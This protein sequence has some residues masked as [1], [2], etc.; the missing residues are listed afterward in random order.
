MRLLTLT[1]PGGV[2]KTRLALAV[3]ER[4]G[5]EFV[6]GVWFVPLAALHDPAYVIPAVVAALGIAE[7]PD[8]SPVQRL[9]A[10]LGNQRVL[11]VLDNVEHVIDAAA[12]VGEVLANCPRL[13]LLATSRIPL[14]L[15]GEREYP[16]PP[17][18]L[19]AG[20]DAGDS[21][22]VRLFVER[23]R[24]VQ[25]S[26]TLSDESVPV[27]AA[28]CR[29]LDGLPLAIELAAARLRM[30]PPKDLLARLDQPLALLTGGP[31]DAPD[32][33]RTLRATIRWSYD[34][35]DEDEQRLFRTMSACRG[36]WTLDATEA[37][38]DDEPD[39]FDHLSTLVEHGL[40][41]QLQS[42]GRA[43][44]GMLEIVRE[45]G[46]EQLTAL[47]E[48]DDARDRHARY[49]LDLVKQRNPIRSE[50]TFAQ[51]MGEIGAELDNIRAAYDWVLAPDEPDGSL[52]DAVAATHEWLD[53]FWRGCGFF[54]EGRR[55]MERTLA[56]PNLSDPGRVFSLNGAGYM[57]TEQGDFEPAISY[58]EEAMAI[59]LDR[60]DLDAQLDALFGL[61]RI[62]LWRADHE[63]TV[64][65][66]EQGLAIA[67]EIG[68]L[69]EIA[70]F[71]SNIAL[72]VA[73]LGDTPRAK[74]LLEEAL[75]IRRN[76]RQYLTPILHQEL[77][78]IAVM[79][80]DTGE[81]RRLLAEALS[82]ERQHGPS[83][84]IADCLEASASL[85]VIEERPARAARLYGA[86]EML[87]YTIGA[88][89]K[90]IDLEVH[91][92]S[93]V[94][95]GKALVSEQAWDEAWAEGR[96]M[97]LDDAID[98]ALAFDDE[99]ESQ[100][101]KASALLSARE[102]EVLRLL[103]D[104]RSN[105]EIAAELFISPHTAANHVASIMNKLGVGSRTAAATWAV[106]NGLV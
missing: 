63:R 51:I 45:F 67:R 32:R 40:V 10:R 3:V 98:Y 81:A 48:S 14:H 29:K 64:E 25:P 31:R 36:G 94:E 35:L 34:L 57:A 65:I 39:A 85:A 7:H 54:A 86:A 77:A 97:P 52:L 17:L 76:V 66:H 50:L 84:I 82:T 6:D 60:G 55:W 47:G 49:F 71:L 20:D 30:F 95:V 87:R 89:L 91:Y 42:E 79:E 70:G 102:T 59:A 100:T 13:T 16:V 23:A 27:V 58:H 1:G 101:V 78:T 15:Y 19:P 62:P 106:R 21:A 28:I 5:E 22:A 24:A 90:P 9:I 46:L 105:H 96:G 43:R 83:R 75:A 99:P 74:R 18:D 37:L 38:S 72:P 69:D 8:Y 41:R 33:Q 44:F 61:G 26:F 92:A 103:V 11:L 2:G 56:K 12:D 80:R 53:Y 88:P 73:L 104:G 68:D 93:Y 4:L